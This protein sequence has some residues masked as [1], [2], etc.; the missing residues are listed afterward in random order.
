MRKSLLSFLGMSLGVLLIAASPASATDVAPEPTLQLSQPTQASPLAA[1]SWAPAS[2][3]ATQTQTFN[4]SFKASV[5]SATFYTSSE[6]TITVNVTPT[7]C[8]SA[9]PNVK[10]RLFNVSIATW[11]WE[12]P[13]AKTVSCNVANIVSFTGTGQGA[14]QVQ[15]DRTGPSGKDEGTKTVKGTIYHAP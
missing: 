15:F 2:A 12:V 11:T 6:S 8:S 7:G 14:F 3:R 5:R 9:Y 1:G 10:V 13:S 4:G